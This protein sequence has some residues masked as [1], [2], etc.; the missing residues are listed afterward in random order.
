MHENYVLKQKII[1]NI[2]LN[3][4]TEIYS[5]N[6]MLLYFFFFSFI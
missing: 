6:L 1:K 4:T 5:Q 2:E 3:I